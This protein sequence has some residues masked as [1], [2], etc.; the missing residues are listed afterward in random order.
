MCMA[1]TLR[2]ANPPPLTTRCPHGCPDTAAVTPPAVTTCPPLS[3]PIGDFSLL[4]LVGLAAVTRVE[5]VRVRGPT[6]AAGV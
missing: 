4:E 6:G 5:A 1:L 2:N 3:G